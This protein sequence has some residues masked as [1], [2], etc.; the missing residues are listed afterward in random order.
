MKISLEAQGTG[1][2]QA[3]AALLGT[4]VVGNRLSIP[5]HLGAGH[6]QGYLFS[7]HFRLMIRNYS[8][9]EDLTL[10]RTG[11][12]AGPNSVILSFHNIFP[13]GTSTTPHATPS[14]QIA[15]GGMNSEMFYPSNTLLPSIIIS[16]DKQWLQE[17]LPDTP[18]GNSLFR[19]LIHTGQPYFIEELIPPAIS[20][21]GNEMLRADTSSTLHHLYMRIKSEELI[22]HLFAALEH[23]TQASYSTIN[24]ADVA[25]AYAV[26]NT[27]LSD[28]SAAPTIN[29]LAAL[30]HMSPTKLKRLFLQIFGHSIYHYF[31]QARMQEAARLFTQEKL[32][33]SETGYRLGFTNLSHFSRL[34]SRHMGM[35]PKKYSITP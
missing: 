24:H 30:A 3:F 34:F 6:I 26:R 28:L 21:I 22:Y 23:R 2:L 29:A 17:N 16:I 10:T 33:V 11:N 32:S 12:Q 5:T 1:I 20:A 19:Q 35:K 13:S 15:A 9:N 27:L 8:L 31:Q 7:P 4:T 25:A 18:T 14:V